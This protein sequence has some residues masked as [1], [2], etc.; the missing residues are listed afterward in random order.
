MKELLKFK[1]S[2]SA[3]NGWELQKTNL[4]YNLACG[5]I[6]FIIFIIYRDFYHN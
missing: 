2:L 3:V 1:E 5:E 6:Q 4:A